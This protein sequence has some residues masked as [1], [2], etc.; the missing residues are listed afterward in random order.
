MDYGK[1]MQI[2]TLM[3]IWFTLLGLTTIVKIGSLPKFPG[4]LPP[5]PLFPPHTVKQFPGMNEFK[6]FQ[7][8]DANV[9]LDFTCCSSS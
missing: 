5:I 8:N 1:G 6:N 4:L 9:N 7:K 3:G 2:Y